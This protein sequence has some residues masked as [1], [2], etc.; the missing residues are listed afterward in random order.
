VSSGRVL[1]LIGPNGAGKSTCLNVLAGTFAADSGTVSFAGHD[2]THASADARARLGL[3]RTFQLPRVPADATVLELAMLGSYRLAGAGVVRGLFG[4]TLAEQQAMQRAGR[5]ALAL[6]GIE[7]LADRPARLLST[8]QQKMLEFAR[9]LASSP[10][11]LL[12]DEP[13]G[14][15][16]E[17]EVERVEELLRRLADRGM[18]IVLVE[19]EMRLVMSVCDEIVVLSEGRVIGS[20]TP[21]AVRTNQEVVDA[22][23]GV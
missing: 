21:D 9:A 4:P 1:G 20:G 14:G 13:A 8:G 5:E 22:Y 11:V 3:A 19:H 10:T 18:A 12:V 17:Q 15:L 23:L 6:T 7:H 2:V 16:F